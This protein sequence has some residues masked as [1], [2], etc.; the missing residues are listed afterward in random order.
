MNNNTNNTIDKVYLFKIE[1]KYYATIHE[2][3]FD[4]ESSFDGEISQD[5]ASMNY[6]ITEHKRSDI[7][8]LPKEII[9]F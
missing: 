4:A 9:W 3:Q 7:S 1:N 8:S 5:H 2:T 6:E